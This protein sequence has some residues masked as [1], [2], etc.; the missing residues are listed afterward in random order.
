[1]LSTYKLYRNKNYLCVYINNIYSYIIYMWY[2]IYSLY[3][4]Y[5]YVCMCI[6]I[7][8][9]KVAFSLWST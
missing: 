6:Y 5:L 8:L 3:M 7:W 1:M 9:L 2:I 4:V